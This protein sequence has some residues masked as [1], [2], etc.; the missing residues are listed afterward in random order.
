MERGN[1]VQGTEETPVAVP[2]P[3]M[4]GAWKKALK[5]AQKYRDLDPLQL[6]SQ[7]D[8]NQDDLKCL[9]SSVLQDHQSCSQDHVLITTKIL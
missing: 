2:V 4:K 9:I 7:F 8:F 3:K 6:K 5:I 1:S